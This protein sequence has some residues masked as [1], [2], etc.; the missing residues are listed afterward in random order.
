MQRVLDSSY[1]E[2]SGSNDDSLPR[3]MLRLG[4]FSFSIDNLAYDT[5]KTEAT[6]NWS[7]Q[8]RIG[9]RDLLQ[10]TGKGA[11]TK[12]LEGQ[13]HALFGRSVQAISELYQLGDG[14]QPL[15]LVSSNGDVM[16][17][18]VVKSVSDSTDSV[19]PGG[20]AR[21]KTFSMAIQ[22]YGDDLSNP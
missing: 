11:P 6:W 2:T 15:Q 1:V 20:F 10:Y 19:L 5:L 21:R 3:V 12:T 16:G 18:W 22:Y 14:A 9:K 8:G 7:E 13:A 4:G 17:Y